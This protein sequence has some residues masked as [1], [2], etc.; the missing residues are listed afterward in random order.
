MEP[1]PKIGACPYCRTPLA[2]DDETCPTCG[3]EVEGAA[4]HSKY[5]RETEDRPGPRVSGP[6]SD[7]DDR[8]G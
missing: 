4:R 3:R 6:G 8:E 1:E 7:Q 5:Q 2:V